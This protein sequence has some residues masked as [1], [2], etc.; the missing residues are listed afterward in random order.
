MNLITYA[1]QWLAALTA[2]ALLV[3]AG[4]DLIRLRISNITV[5]VV[6]ASAIA[7]MAFGG[8]HGP[9]WQNALVF[10]GILVLGTL[11]FA[12][13]LLGGGDVKL[14]AAAG[15]WVGFAAAPWRLAAI[16]VLFIV[17]RKLRGR[18]RRE[19]SRIPYG[20]AIAAGAIFVLGTQ[21]SN[22]S[23]SRAE[24]PLPPIKGLHLPQR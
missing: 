1:P 7:A 8:F 20:V 14:L 4:E 12:R 15:L 6:L 18:S 24:R 16:A 19:G 5:L 23:A 21:Y 17:V 22:G 10:A 11:A 2:A 13:E 3:A 9:L